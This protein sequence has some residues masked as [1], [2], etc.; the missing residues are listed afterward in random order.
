MRTD[1]A[2]KEPFTL[3]VLLRYKFTILI[4]AAFVILGGYVR[5]VTQPVLHEAKARL[6][7][8]FT[9]EAL[10][11]NSVGQRV[12]SFFRLPLLEEEVKAYMVQITDPQFLNQV[13]DALP[14]DTSARPGVDPALEPSAAE[15]FRAQFLKAYYGIRE[16]ILAMVDAFLMTPDK[17]ISEREQRVMQVLSRLEVTS[18]T[19]ASHILTVNF[20]NPD[21]V[22]AADVVN[23]LALKFIEH[24]KKK[25][26]QRD[27]AKARQAVD[28]AMKALVENRKKLLGLSNKIGS[29]TLEDAIQ[30]KY[31]AVQALMDRK[32]QFEL[33]LQLLEQGIVPYNTELPLET[34]ILRSELER[35]YFVLGMEWE[36]DLQAHPENP[37]YYADLLLL[38]RERMKERGQEAI[39]RDI[40]VVKT[41]IASLDQKATGLTG[42]ALFT[43]VT[44]EWAQAFL[45]QSVIESRLRAAEGE[46]QSVKEFNEELVN[47][48][49]SE[50]IALW[51]K[52]QVPPFPMPQ[53]RGLK[54]LVVVAL[55][56][57]AGC[58]A[59]LLRHQIR[60]KPV[61]QAR[62]RS[63][64][65]LDV[66]LII[67][68]DD[69]SKA[70]EKDL[71]L[72]ISF[73]EDEESRGKPART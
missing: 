63:E 46:L 5:V 7:V 41:H 52:A 1:A 4:I 56:F 45:A 67:L 25:V 13:L 14:K 32:S 60:P 10:A 2:P 73:P 11:L 18:G 43:N 54:I 17:L 39:K 59:A 27:E 21:P 61:R 44:P 50:N 37:K 3:Q 58:A 9:A 36:K 49:V 6:A 35:Q 71:E 20:Q 68:P 47:E 28:E 51:Q 15:R 42:D 69:G 48:N 16:S 22:Y 29:S 8:R 55:G 19:E 53:H 31:Q 24:Q 38:A 34:P 70:L 65:E 62:P 57:F 33:A 72:D 64:E 66:P 40:T 12:D 30:K 23:T 26:K